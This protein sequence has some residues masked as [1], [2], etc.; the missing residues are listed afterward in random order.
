[1]ATVNTMER[2]RPRSREGGEASSP[3]AG[4]VTYEEYLA[5]ADEGLRRHELWYGRLVELEMP[6]RYNQHFIK[7]FL[8]LFE[9]WLAA[10]G[11]DSWS[12]NSPTA[13]TDVEVR[14]AGAPVVRPDI[15]IVSAARKSIVGPRAFNGVPDVVIELLSKSQQRYVEH[16]RV[17]KMTFYARLGVPLYLIVDVEERRA[18]PYHLAEGGYVAGPTLSDG[19]VLRFEAVPGFEAPLSDLFPPA[20]AVLSEDTSNDSLSGQA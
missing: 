12:P 14:V 7:R 4:L 5:R 1:M 9:A 18:E 17:D 10:Q 20:D 6:V 2:P 8:A 11:L 3:D 13:E 16:D 15:T 19:D